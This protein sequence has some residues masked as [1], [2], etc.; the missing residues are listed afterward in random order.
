[1]GIE[2]T[3]TRMFLQLDTEKQQRVLEAAIDEFAERGYEKA[4][5]NTVVKKAGI[6]KGALFKY[7]GNKSGLF[8]FVYRIALNHV[9]RLSADRAW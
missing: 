1:M 3:E 2:S 5:M 6:S 8:A 7:F 4:S 9:K